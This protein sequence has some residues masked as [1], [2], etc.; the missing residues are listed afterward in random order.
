M[1]MSLTGVAGALGSGAPIAHKLPAVRYTSV[2][3]IA[4]AIILG[5]ILSSCL[6]PEVEKNEEMKA[7][8]NTGFQLYFYTV[9]KYS[10]HF[11]KPLEVE[12]SKAQ[13]TAKFYKIPIL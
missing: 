8:S 9:I 6:D 13:M 12:T 1:K 11:Q 2:M 7:D 10:V 3:P 4:I 5:F